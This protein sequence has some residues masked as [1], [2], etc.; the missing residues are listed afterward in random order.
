MMR[1]HSNRVVYNREQLINIAEAKRRAR[2]RKFK[3]SL[4]AI[5]MG[6]VRSLANKL[7]E[8][9]ALIR[10]QQEYRKCSIMC[11][12]E[13]WLQDHIPDSNISLLGFL[14]IRADRDLISSR[15]RKGVALAV[16]VN[17]RWCHPG[18]VT[19]KCRLCNPDIELL[20]VSFRPYYLPREF[21]GVVLEAVYIPPSAVADNTCDVISSIVAKIQTQHPNSFMAI[22]GDFNHASLSATLPTFQ[23]FVSCFTRENKTLDLFYT[24]LFSINVS[25]ISVCLCS[26]CILVQNMLRLRQVDTV[27]ASELRNMQEVLLS[28][29]TEVVQSE[30]TAKGLSTESLR[31]QQDLEKVQQLEGKITCELTTLKEQISTMESDLHT[32]RDLDTLKYTAEEKKKKLTGDQTSLTQHRDSFKQ[33][34]EEKNQKYDALKTKLQENETYAQ[35]ANLERKWQHVE[36]NI[37]VMKECILQSYDFNL[38][39]T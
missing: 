2:R 27:T 9:Q 36:Q 34:L 26:V 20:V 3:P 22:S 31:L 6:N 25:V 16:L 5:I 1:N 37:F 7:D 4:P 23:Q 21:T 28:K 32:Y 15:K 12:T 19:V 30:S 38:S 29:E 8:L 11:F 13:A 10:T 18:H 24:I 17:N 39:A 14:T 33:L 35:L